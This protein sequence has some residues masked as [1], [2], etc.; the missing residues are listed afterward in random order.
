MVWI[1]IDLIIGLFRLESLN[2]L[3][4]GSEIESESLII[5]KA[6][7]IINYKLSNKKIFYPVAYQAIIIYRKLFVENWLVYVVM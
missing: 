7:E 2:H 3:K 4:W 6:S 5:I 1:V